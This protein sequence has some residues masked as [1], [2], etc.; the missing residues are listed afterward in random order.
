MLCKHEGWY[1]NGDSND[2]QECTDNTKYLTVVLVPC[3]AIACTFAASILMYYC[4]LPAAKACKPK[5]R[6]LLKVWEGLRSFMVKVCADASNWLCV[7][8]L[9][10]ERLAFAGEDRVELLPGGDLDPGCL[11]SAAS[12]AS[13]RRS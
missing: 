6:R 5:R 4:S 8:S 3:L 11:P 13:E 10:A 1:F 9:Q 12:G 2:C 7:R